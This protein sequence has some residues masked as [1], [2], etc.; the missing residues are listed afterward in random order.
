MSVQSSATPDLSLAAPPSRPMAA[1]RTYLWSVRRELWENRSIWIAPLVVVGVIL[2]GFIFSLVRFVER[3]LQTAALAPAKQAAVHAEIYDFATM[4]VIVASMV[5]GVFYCLGA[6]QGERRDRSILFWKSLPV[7]DLTTVL[8]KATIPLVVIPTVAYGLAIAL[9]L[10][11]LLVSA[12][13]LSANGV[14]PAPLW[15]AATPVS[16]PVVLLYALVTLSLWYAPIYGWLLL[17]SAWARRVTFLWAFGPPFGL[18]L[19]DAIAFHGQ[20]FHPLVAYRLIGGLKAAFTPHS[21]QPMG[22]ADMD[23]LRFLASPGLWV[24]LAFAAAFLAAAV[25]LR[26]RRAPD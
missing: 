9:R 22:L 24:G 3:F 18:M 25:W 1:R 19:F 23:P 26:R 17:V 4:A 2:V 7:S 16:T 8:A 13:V 6:L 11:M 5:V 20:L 14:D 12:L 21:H 10:V 15:V